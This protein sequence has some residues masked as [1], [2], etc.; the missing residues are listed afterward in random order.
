M[1]SMKVLAL[2]VGLAGLALGAAGLGC[3]KRPSFACATA[4]E[5]GPGGACEADG[6]C[7]FVDGACASGRRY[8]DHSGPNAG[9]CVGEG[10][11]PDGPPVDEAPD[12][13]VADARQCFG[14]GAYEVCLM[15]AP[16]GTVT[17]AGALDTDTDSRCLAA[18][19]GMWTTNGQP[20]ACF[21]VGEQITVTG[22]LSVT[23]TRPLALIAPDLTVMALLDVASHGATVGPAGNAAACA[24]FVSDPAIG[25]DPDNV[26]AG[27]AGGSFR[28]KG[29]NGGVADMNAG[30]FPGG[31]SPAADGATPTVLRGGCAGQLGGAAGAV[32]GPPGAGG[33]VVF[34]AATTLT[35]SAGGIVNA[36]GGGANAGGI[37][38]GGSGGGTG[39]MIVLHADSVAVAGGRLLANGGGGASGG[40][41]TQ[42]GNAGGDPPTN[43]VTNGGDGGNNPG[44]SGG[45]GFATGNNPADAGG[46]GN[47]DAGGGGG[48]G[49]GYIQS[50]R[51]LTGA[52]VSPAP[53][54][55][56]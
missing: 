34:L 28:T 32:A 56:P 38:A 22:A 41:E 49:G 5:C 53:T 7:S 37:G 25:A 31:V 18:Q 36:S 29:G 15:A 33:G 54:I 46:T 14:A 11:L 6:F 4:D 8:G 47:A 43:N 1:R 35:I 19:P 44:G 24:A 51:A 16:T 17:L 27:G 2:I 48:G 39:G 23:G 52:S 12:V 9:Q 10:I 3:L 26:G 42:S 30:T 50:N 40:R 45:E 55:V 13:L 21:I 20:D